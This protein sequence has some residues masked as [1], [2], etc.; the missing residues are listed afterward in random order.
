MLSAVLTLVILVRL[1]ALYQDLKDA[2]ML[3]EYGVT[4]SGLVFAHRSLTSGKGCRTQADVRYTVQGIVHTAR[5]T[6]CGA[7]PNNLPIG[8]EVNVRFLRSDPAIATV[9]APGVE[10]TRP[11]WPGLLLMLGALLLLVMVTC[12]E[13]LRKIAKTQCV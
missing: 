11:D 2:R 8:R 10:E 4:T 1:P 12:R 9:V 6:G 3:R 7:S 5:I 13:W